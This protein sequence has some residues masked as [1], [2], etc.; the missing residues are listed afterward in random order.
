MELTSATYIQELTAGT[1]AC[2]VGYDKVYRG[3]EGKLRSLGLSPGTQFQV[4]GFD[5]IE[6]DLGDRI[7]Y[8]SRSEATA[9]VVEAIEPD[10]R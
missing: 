8:L 1:I 2:I 5:P 6:I 3:Y 10:E 7:I 4:L 9:L